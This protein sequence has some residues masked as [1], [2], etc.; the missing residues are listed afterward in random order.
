MNRRAIIFLKLT[1]VIAAS[2]VIYLIGN[3]QVNLWD[4]DEPRYAVTSRQMLS[5]GDWV[6]PEFL[7]Q[8]RLA[9][10]PL[11]YWCQAVAMKFMGATDDAARMPSAVSMF[12]LLIVLGFLIWRVVGPTRALW[13]VFIFATSGLAIAAAKMCLT[14]ALLTLWITIAQLC[15]YKIWREGWNWGITIAFG[16]AVGLAGLTKGP[17]VLGVIAMTL[18]ALTVLRLLVPRASRPCPT[19]G[20]GRDAGGTGLRL[21]VSILIV[22]VLV[23]PWVLAMQHRIP[24]YLTNTLWKEVFQRTTQAAEGHK[25]PPGY[26]LLTIWVTYF[27]WSLLLPAAIVA[28]FKNLRLPQIRF[29][30]AA[31]L[32]PWVMF[33]VVQTKLPHYLLPVFPFLAFLTAELLIRASRKTVADLSNRGFR[34][35]VSI[36]MVIVACVGSAPWLSLIWF[37]NVSIVALLMMALLSIAAV[38]YGRLVYREF[39]EDRPLRAAGVLGGGMLVIVAIAYAGVLPNLPFLRLSSQIAAVIPKNLP[40]GEAVMIDYKEPTVAWY[41]GGTIREQPD[42]SYLLHTDPTAWPSWIVVTDRIWQATPDAQRSRL[43]IAGRLSGLWYA[44]RNQIGDVLVLKKK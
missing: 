29:A 15:V 26:Y 22:V 10:P 6:V 18:I 7:G 37:P 30:L 11:V 4:R 24:G 1:L 32:G 19:P 23:A 12:L 16:I 34:T 8:P 42:D 39:R 13:T 27:P 43:E 41:Q 25:G 2:T 3:G 20:H 38:L 33:E 44:N 9:K 5:S 14:D 35:S 17:V 28:A 31:V 36:W 40:I 21:A